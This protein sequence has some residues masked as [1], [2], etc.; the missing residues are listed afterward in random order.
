MTNESVTDK[1]DLNKEII[2]W[3]SHHLSSHGYALK[4]SLPEIVQET[5]WSYVIRFE[6]SDGYIY[7]KQTLK[8]I[9]LEAII[10]HA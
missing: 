5:P 9:A 7:L 2:Q 6:I 10:S 3:G 4:S 1:N 8:L